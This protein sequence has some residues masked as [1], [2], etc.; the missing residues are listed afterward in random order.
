MIDLS[1]AYKDRRILVTGGTGFLGKHLVSRLA[2]LGANVTAFDIQPSPPNSR[3]KFIQG[4]IRSPEDIFRA[5]KGQELVFHL[6]GL[7]G[8]EKIVDI[9]LEVLDVNLGGTINALKAAVENGVERFVFTS[10]SEIYGQPRRIPIS[11]TDFAAPIST[12]GVSKLAAES[13]CSA[14]ARHHGFKYTIVRLFNVYGPEQ[15][16]KFVMPIFISRITKGLPPIIYGH[17]SQSRSYTFI[18]D[19]I[20]GILRAGASKSGE[21]EVFNIGNDEEIRITE[22]AEFIIGIS[23]NNLKPTYRPFGDGVRVE[24]REILRRQPDIS[25]AAMLLGFKPKVS[26][27]EGVRRFREWYINSSAGLGQEETEETP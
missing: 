24:K 4:D 15:T 2:E 11:E 10:S 6:A 18:T 26:W 13:Y 9:P 17:G 19:A 8:V 1:A 27:R 14:Y 16:E 23:G 20:E 25:K 5:T 7:L 21:N 3:I 22:L 12:Y